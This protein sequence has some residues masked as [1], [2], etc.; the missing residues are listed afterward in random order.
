M[1]IL[2]GEIEESRRKNR[3]RLRHETYCAPKIFSQGGEWP[4]DWQGRALLA[5]ACHY[6][7]ARTQEERDDVY[8]QASEIL[9]Q[10]PEHL[11]E[12]GY[13]GELCDFDCVNEQQ[14][15]GNGWFLR[16]LCMW[17]EIT[18]DP[19]IDDLLRKITDSLLVRLAPA[20]L[21]YPAGAREDGAISGHLQNDV[22]SGWKL[23]T[24]VGCA[25]ILLDGMTDVYE[26]TKSE[27]LGAVIRTAISVFEKIDYAACHC[28]THATLTAARGILRFW[29][30]TGEERYLRIAESVFKLYL[31]RGMTANYAN[32]NWFGKP[33]WTEPCAVTDSL[34][35]ATELFRI[36]DD[37]FYAQT[38]N[39]IYFNAF[40]RAQRGNGG[41]G[42]DSCLCESN[43]ELKILSYEAPFCCTMRYAEGLLCLYENAMYEQ[44][45]VITVLFT[46]DCCGDKTEIIREHYSD[47]VRIIVRNPDAAEFRVY[48]PCH[49]ETE[50]LRENGFVSLCG[51][52][53]FEIKELPHTEIIAGATVRMKA[54]VVLL[55]NAAG[56]Y[57][58]IQ[59]CLDV[60]PEGIDKN[61]F[62]L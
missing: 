34:M 6:K 12:G 19:E 58:P 25:F 15:S 31:K 41:A 11:N 26:K 59:N 54:D 29:K 37:C 40:R 24:D 22:I 7:T 56:E 38:A 53:S 46:L 35:L 13:F 2:Y 27:K 62:S 16:G 30:T 23:S 5:L 48:V 49:A 61:I 10:S 14:L 32:F 20:Y 1:N 51:S 42:C 36:T 44:N 47:K 52:R 17:S 50:I 57:A 33:F 18:A 21:Q 43:S 39:R 3:E 55:K 28:Q 9:R 8:S 60:M 45:G 4:G